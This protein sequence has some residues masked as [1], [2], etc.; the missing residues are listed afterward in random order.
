MPD[1][2]NPQAVVFANEKIRVMADLMASNYL[3]AKT[4][5]ADWNALSMSSLITNTSDNI[6]DGSATDGR[7]PITGIQATAIVTRAMEIIADY[8]A[9]SNA[10]LNTVLQVKVNGQAK[11]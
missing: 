2:T 7:S 6:V 3:T 4:L 8:E 5:V 11:F 1:I 10:K 9:G